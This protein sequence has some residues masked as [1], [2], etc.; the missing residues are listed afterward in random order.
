M[1]LSMVMMGRE[2]I[3]R[4][5]WIH[6]AKAPAGQSEQET[7]LGCQFRTAFSPQHRANLCHS[8]GSRSSAPACSS[9]L[10]FGA[11]NSRNFYPPKQPH[12]WYL[13]CNISLVHTSAM[14]CSHLHV[15]S[16][17]NYAAQ[18]NHGQS[19]IV[20]CHTF[21]LVALYAGIFLK[22]QDV[23]WLGTKQAEFL[24]VSNDVYTKFE[25][26]NVSFARSSP[27]ATTATSRRRHLKFWISRNVDSKSH[28]QNSQ[29]WS[30]NRLKFKLGICW[31]SHGWDWNPSIRSFCISGSICLFKWTKSFNSW[32][33]WNR[34]WTSK[35][36]RVNACQGSAAVPVDKGSWPQNPCLRR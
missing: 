28:P 20:V 23:R 1:V 10:T 11:C 35:F 33:A 25:T 4:P 14:S 6:Q 34:L 7:L 22:K 13:C 19:Q 16:P 2:E 21:Q 12:V 31:G 15:P 18:S 17:L 29:L 3:V 8:L 24:S 5:W 26:S 27:P 32:L 30:G 9:E 36:V